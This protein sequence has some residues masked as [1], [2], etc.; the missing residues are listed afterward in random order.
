MT[1]QSEVGDLGGAVGGQ[2]NIG[3][4]EIAMHRPQHMRGIHRPGQCLDQ[5]DC[6]L[7]RLGRT[8]EPVSQA[9]PFD[10]FELQIRKPV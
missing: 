8:I 10:E 5:P 2:Q 1:R 7:G 9:T 3:R 6:V 4:L